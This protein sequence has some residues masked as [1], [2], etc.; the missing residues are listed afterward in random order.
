MPLADPSTGAPAPYAQ[1]ALQL[2]VYLGHALHSSNSSENE[3]I[4][5]ADMSQFGFASVAEVLDLCAAF[6]T[7]SFTLSSPSLAPVGVAISPPVALFNHSCW[8]NAVVVF[9]FG[10]YGSK[11][12]G[13][14][15]DVVA[16]RDL[17][18]GEQIVTAYIDISLPSQLR[19]TELQTRYFFKCDCDL[20]AKPSTDP[21]E[22]VRP[23]ESYDGLEDW[24]LSGMKLL[25]MEQQGT[26]VDFDQ[27][28]SKASPMSVIGSLAYFYPPWAYPLFPLVRLVCTLL[29]TSLGAHPT[30]TD[31]LEDSIRCALLVSECMG[32]PSIYPDNHPVRALARAELGKLLLLPPPPPPLLPV[33]QHS[34]NPS[35]AARSVLPK[36][37]FDLAQTKIESIPR[38]P[39]HRLVLARTVLMDALRESRVG[40]GKPQGGLVGLEIA[41]LVEGVSRE[42]EILKTQ[43][44]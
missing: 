26:L 23:R 43:S 37:L 25:K 10:G 30:D 4:P 5:P 3:E 19:Q 39:I 22:M 34:P 21:R 8:P 9:P 11:A 41:G 12:D 44:G 2:G 33:P 17:V 13:N 35:D 27:L 29:V 36:N 28:L 1:L 42:I 32:L 24:V 40:F 14:C 20:C 16:L 7:N 15:M 38:D 6:M 31:R 18:P